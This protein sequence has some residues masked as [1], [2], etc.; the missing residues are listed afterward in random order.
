MVY[1]VIGIMSGSSLDGMDIVFTEL[2]EQAG[3]WNMKLIIQNVS[4]MIKN[5]IK[6]CSDAVVFQQK[7]IFY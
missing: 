1:K 2:Q 5:G 6:N 3:K 4:L 7:N